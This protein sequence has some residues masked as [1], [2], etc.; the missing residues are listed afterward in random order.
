M[1]SI[2]IP[3]LRLAVRG[4]PSLRPG[5]LIGQDTAPAQRLDDILLRPR[6]IP[7]AVSVLDTQKERAA[8]MTGKK[9]IEQGGA[10][11]ADM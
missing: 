11:P 7:A 2:K 4:I 10:Y 3:A 1:L 5:P 6:H 9:I 8:V